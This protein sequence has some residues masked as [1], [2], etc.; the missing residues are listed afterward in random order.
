MQA[1]QQP[2][3]WVGKRRTK[4]LQE[5]RKDQC[6]PVRAQSLLYLE[7][8]VSETAGAVSETPGFA[9]LRFQRKKQ[10]AGCICI[11]PGGFLMPPALQV[12]C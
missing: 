2:K 1:A 5:R 6:R 3:S 10:I 8:G 11:P 12:E 9:A 7:P 4:A